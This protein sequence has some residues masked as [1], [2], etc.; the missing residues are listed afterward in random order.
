MLRER[1]GDFSTK[2]SPWCCGEQ[3]GRLSAP[4]TAPGGAEEKGRFQ[5]QGRRLVL[6]E[7]RRELGPLGA[8]VM[9]LSPDRA[10][11]PGGGVYT[12]CLVCFSQRPCKREPAQTHL[13]P[14]GPCSPPIPCSPQC[15][16]QSHEGEVFGNAA[17]KSRKGWQSPSPAP[18]RS[19]PFHDCLRPER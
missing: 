2:D 6:R 14:R 11:G 10:L 1:R 13:V 3:K 17:G 19:R 18:V 12:H 7:R 16:L 4:R 8:T 5:H 15:L 9:T